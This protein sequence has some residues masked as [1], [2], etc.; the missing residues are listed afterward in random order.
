MEDE[1]AELKRSTSSTIA[2][3]K[4]QALRLER[5]VAMLHEE[6]SRTQELAQQQKD[7]ARGLREQLETLELEPRR[8]ERKRDDDSWQTVRDE[9][10][11]TLPLVS[12][13]AEPL[14]GALLH[15]EGQSTYIKSVE[16]ANLKLTAENQRLR[17][18]H[19]NAELLRVEK[20]RLQ[21]KVA[22]GAGQEVKIAQLEAELNVARKELQQWYGAR[23]LPWL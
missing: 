7:T 9:L 3:Q 22:E 4:A 6:L 1:N 20:L 2:D 5:Q 18:K 23:L 10:E 15:S 8:S 16:N 21:K 17:A 19:E 14:T 12:F 13:T 11:R